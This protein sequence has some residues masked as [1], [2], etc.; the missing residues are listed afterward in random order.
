[1]EKF[2][3]TEQDRL[4]AFEKEWDKSLERRMLEN[5]LSFLN[6]ANI[7]ESEEIDEILQRLYQLKYDLAW[8]WRV[9]MLV[10]DK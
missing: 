5:R 3:H 9:E 7:V 8:S 2:E 10:M 4:S 6:K 1:M